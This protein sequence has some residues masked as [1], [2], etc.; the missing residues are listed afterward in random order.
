MFLLPGFS[1]QEVF[2]Y[3][4]KRVS[5]QCSLQNRGDNLYS[6]LKLF[7]ADV[8]LRVFGVNIRLNVGFN[9]SWGVL[10]VLVS[11]VCLLMLLL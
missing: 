6:R 5:K 4:Q 8:S 2:D 11:F 1:S 3:I 9:G 10:V 7:S